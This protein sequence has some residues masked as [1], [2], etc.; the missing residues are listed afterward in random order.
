M[1]APLQSLI[2]S[3]TKLW[4]DSVDPELVMEYR[5][6]GATGATSNPAIISGLLTSGRFDEEFKT[7]LETEPVDELVAWTMTDRLVVSAQQ[8][9]L[10]VWQSSEGDDGYVS[11]E[12]DPLIDGHDSPLSHD[13]R[14]DRYIAEATRWSAGH[15]NRLIKVPATP[16]GLDALETLASRGIPLN[17]TLI[18]TDHQY[19]SARDAIW[20][21]IKSC[22]KP[23][24]FKSVY[25]IFVSRIDVYT[26]QYVG[27]LS[28]AAQ[29]LVGI[30]NAKRIWRE[31]QQFWSDK[32]TKL[33]QEI[34][35]ASTGTKDPGDF[36]W[37]YVDALAGSD[38]QTN[39]PPTNQAIQ[40]SA[41]T[42]SRQV[43]RLPADEVLADIDRHVDFANMEEVLMR[44]GIDKFAQ[45]HQML[46]QIVAEKRDSLL[47]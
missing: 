13:A 46:M 31:N 3:G 14:V 38:I 28:P 32:D 35:F 47:V 21:G 41:V 15:Q 22:A 23:E 37:K 43:D 4:L 6:L 33:A 36:P 1:S 39:P 42:F 5:S 11:F 44:E 27:E 9:F 7:L 29:G 20:R 34:V 12:V 24:L 25:S 26:A 17:V 18:F 2:E 40:G 16:A 8:R 30:V 10:D 45:P 19:R